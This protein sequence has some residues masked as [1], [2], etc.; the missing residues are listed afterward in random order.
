LLKQEILFS[1]RWLVVQNASFDP[2]VTFNPYMP[3]ARA[4]EVQMP[5]AIHDERRHTDAIVTAAVR[6]TRDVID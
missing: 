5:L 4:M 6:A 1:H 2:A 3:A